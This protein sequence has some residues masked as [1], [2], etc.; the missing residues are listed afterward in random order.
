ALTSVDV[1]CHR[2]VTEEEALAEMR[3]GLAPGGILVLQVPAF[4]WLRSQHDDAGWTNRRYPR[5][6]G[7]E[8]LR[9]SGFE[10]ESAHYRV[11]L[12]FPLAVLRRSTRGRVASAK[13]RSDVRPAGPLANALFGSVLRAEALLGSLS[14]H[15]PFGLSVFCVARKPKS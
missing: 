2:F 1:L 13:A 10:V 6:G 5:R 7:E 8:M 11:W 3:R 14:L 4:D 15:L 12:L 9:G